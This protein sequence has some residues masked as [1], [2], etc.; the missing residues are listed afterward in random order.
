MDQPLVVVA[1]D[2][3]DVRDLLTFFLEKA[4]YRTIGAHDGATAARLLTTTRPAAL[5]T[6]VHMPDMNGMD[7][8]RL[9][10]RT[11]ATQDIPIIMFSANT[12]QHD[13]QAGITAG[14]DSYLPK[15][16]SPS[17]VVSRLDELLSAGGLRRRDDVPAHTRAA[18][19]GVFTLAGS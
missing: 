13:M 19:G 15:P 12:H 11:F 3:R 9:A 6:D 1:E 16:L 18:V 5:I 4:G 10:R 8:C 7:L 14:A 17:A 2:D